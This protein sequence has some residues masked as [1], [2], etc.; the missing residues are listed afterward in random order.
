MEA[1]LTAVVVWLS[2]NFSLPASFDH[3]RVEFV[4]AAKMTSL[5]HRD[6]GSKQPAEMPLNQSESNIVSLY[7]DDQRAIYLLE[8]WTGKTPAELSILVH[9]MVHHLQKIGQLKFECPQAREEVAYKAQDRWLGLF[10][11]DLSRDFQVDAFTILVKSK[12]F[13]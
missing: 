3:P 2:T 5:L 6:I 8:E 10:G 4:S 12:C 7:N 1:L 9:E 13:F 11:H